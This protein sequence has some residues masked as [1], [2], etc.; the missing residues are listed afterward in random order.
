MNLMYATFVED[1]FK[2]L[3]LFAAFGL[4]PVC[5]N[6]TV[7]NDT[8]ECF[9]VEYDAQQLICSRED[10]CAFIRRVE[11]RKLS[12][13]DRETLGKEVYYAKVISRQCKQTT[14]D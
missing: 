4:D 7:I 6:C 12:Q 1:K 13:T 9:I 2:Y 14:L 3:A 5:G 8:A 11:P 10:G